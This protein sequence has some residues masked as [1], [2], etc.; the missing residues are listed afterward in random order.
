MTMTQH[1]ADI[2]GAAAG[3]PGCRAVVE[4]LREDEHETYLAEW[5][6]AWMSG[7]IARRDQ[8]AGGTVATEK[9]TAAR[10]AAIDCGEVRA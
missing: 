10:R 2:I 3:D 4:I 9:G 7:Y 5:R 6:H 1:M 8:L